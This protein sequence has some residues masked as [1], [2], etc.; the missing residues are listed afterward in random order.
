M[1]ARA[2]SGVVVYRRTGGP[3]EIDAIDEYSRRL[4]EALGEIGVDARYEP[5][6]LAA[7]VAPGYFGMKLGYRPRNIPRWVA[8]PRPRVHASAVA[9]SPK[10]P[11]VLLQY[12]PF[13]YGRAGFAPGLIRDAARLRRAGVPLALMVHEPWVDMQDPKSILIGS[14]H[15]AQLRALMRMAEAVMTSTESFAR[16][17]GHGAV[18]VPVGTNITPVAADQSEARA[19]LGLD[20]ALTVALLGRAHPSRALDHAEAAIAALARAHGPDGVA[21]L[22]LGADAP[23]LRVPVG[24]AVRAPGQQSES[25][26]S[27]ALTASDLVLLPLVDGVS[28]RRTT[29]MAALA[30]GRTVVALAGERTD[31]LF[32]DATDAVALAPVGDPG[33]FARAAVS[34]AEDP[35]RRRSM[36]NAGRRLYAASFDW[37]VLAGRVAS[38]LDGI[39]REPRR[40]APAAR[41]LAIGVT[42]TH[43]YRQ[44]SGSAGAP[45]VFVAGDVGGPGGMERQSEQLVRRLLDAGRSVTVVA[46]SCAL[47]SHERLRFRRVRTP[48]RPF[49]LAYPAFFIVA[50]FLAA[51]RRGALLHTTGA[52]VFNWAD[53]STVHYC[54]RSAVTRVEG[55]RASRAGRLYKLNAAIARGLSLL[56]ERWCYRPGRTRVLC[57]VSNGVARELE[58]GFPRMRGAVRAVANGVDAGAFRP[59]PGAGGRMRARLGIAADTPLAV[60]VGGDWE[61]KGLRYAVD[62]LTDA[63]DWHLVVAGPGDP[64]AVMS[65]AG[66]DRGASSGGAGPT[67]PETV[68][69]RARGDGPLTRLH[70]LGPVR[71]TPQLYAAADAFVLPTAYEAFPLV[72][73]EAAASALPL[74]VT[75]VNGAEDLIQDG[76]NGWFIDRDGADIARRL[77]QLSADPALAHAM[78]ERSRVAATGYSWE[79]MAA[80]YLSVYSELAPRLQGRAP[81]AARVQTM[82][83]GSEPPRR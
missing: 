67:G 27:L 65:S 4:V 55:S 78:A 83:V 8:V 82:N 75:R 68:S 54:H 24:V 32:A 2:A 61:R 57:A 10:P 51:R 33:A 71:D 6:G 26:M 22:N 23:P 35:E 58:E 41:T 72:I 69:S 63:P 81:P 39:A 46:R 77:N 14:W 21:V 43:T 15:R 38:V 79:A 50:S 74:L 66:S 30:H 29:L 76:R 62:A 18:H 40:I 28:T 25:E 17:L 80:G 36:G 60:F 48:A 16:E 53:V 11:W 44:S 7:V 49:T 37:P 47:P 52:I 56:G 19:Q 1:P 31:A 3:S 20:G 42:Y 12:N 5:G 59:D 45:V 70:F 64:E 9:P 13:R 73:L 34:A